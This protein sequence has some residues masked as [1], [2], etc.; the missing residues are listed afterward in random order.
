M[1]MRRLLG[2]AGLL[3][4]SVFIS[5]AVFAQGNV[6]P[7][8]DWTINLSTMVGIGTAIVIVTMFVSK[9]SNRTEA[10][11]RR[12]GNL[13]EEMKDLTGLSGKFDLIVHRLNTIDNAFSNLTKIMESGARQD[14]R[15]TAVEKDVSE[16]RARIRDLEKG[17]SA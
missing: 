4:L 15:L 1:I 17:D 7:A 2:L 8:F 16:L 14:E 11:S 13:D 3:I 10:L 12:V 5:A 9:G 6:S